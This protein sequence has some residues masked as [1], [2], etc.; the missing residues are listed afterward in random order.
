M[1]LDHYELVHYISKGAF[2]QVWRVRDIQTG[3]EYALKIQIET[4]RATK[5]FA[6]DIVREITTQRALQ[7]ISGVLPLLDMF[8]LEHTDESMNVV[9]RI[10]MIMP[11]MSESL[12]KYMARTILRSEKGAPEWIVARLSIMFELFFILFAVHDAGFV[13]GDLKPENVLLL[14]IPDEPPRVFISDWGLSFWYRY[15]HEQKKKNGK[16]TKTTTTT[17]T[18]TPSTTSA[19]TTTTTTTDDDDNEDIRDEKADQEEKKRRGTR[20]VHHT[21]RT[22]N[23]IYT[24]WWRAPEHLASKWYAYTAKADWWALGQMATD[25]LFQ[26]ATLRTPMGATDLSTNMTQLYVIMFTL[27]AP[28]SL[29]GAPV[30]PSSS[31]NPQVAKE[32][33]LATNV[34][35]EILKRRG[36]SGVQEQLR[37]DQ[38]SEMSVDEMSDAVLDRRALS[39]FGPKGAVEYPHWRDRIYGPELFGDL[40]RWTLDLLQVNPQLRTAKRGIQLFTKY[41]KNLPALERRVEAMKRVPRYM[42]PTRQ[43]VNKHKTALDYIQSRYHGQLSPEEERLAVA[44]YMA[45]F[46]RNPRPTGAEDIKMIDTSVKAAVDLYS[47]G[48]PYMDSALKEEIASYQPSAFAFGWES[49]N[50]WKAIRMETSRTRPERAVT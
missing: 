33:R 19:T 1:Q 9:H 4:M 22:P 10:A 5:P 25:I 24:V 48:I 30:H 39:L 12:D 15:V 41:R 11:L 29:L 26:K 36:A 8:L 14:H 28:E 18:T 27:G 50:P 35:H 20:D 37:L 32:A 43:Y 2:G 3:R 6:S 16:D 45:L 23:M 46:A 31:V 49:W 40:I 44:L 34:Y 47:D 13:H 17:T 42:L 7:N 38:E 21:V